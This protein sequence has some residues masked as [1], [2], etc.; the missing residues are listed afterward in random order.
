MSFIQ[1]DDLTFNNVQMDLKS[2]GFSDHAA[3]PETRASWLQWMH[4]RLDK[5]VSGAVDLSRPMVNFL[6]GIIIL[7]IFLFTSL[8]KVHD[9]NGWARVSDVHVPRHPKSITS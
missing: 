5:G 4:L 6:S 1:Y 9:R 7:I 2:M 8:L 3:I